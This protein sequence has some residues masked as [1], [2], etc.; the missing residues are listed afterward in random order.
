M[1]KALTQTKRRSRIEKNQLKQNIPYF[2]MM[3]PGI[4]LTF[5]F[6]YIPIF[7]IIIAF[8]KY[9]PS[10]GIWG[11]PWNGLK[12]FE[13]IFNSSDT[14]IVLRNTLLYNSVFIIG[15][16]VLNVAVALLLSSLR[17]KKLSKV[18]QTVVIMPHFLS[19]VIVA[20]IV[21]GFLN[22]E[23]GFI[24][25][26]ILEPLGLTPVNWYVDPK[27]W[28]VLL[29]VVNFWKTVGYGSVVYLAAIAGIDAELYE[30]A[31]M[32]GANRWKQIIHITLP[33]IKNVVIIML[34]MNVGKIF[35]SD[36]G[37]FYQVPMNSGALY[38]ATNVINVF[39]YNMLGQGGITGIGMSSAASFFQ[40]VVGFVLVL[41]T[42]SITKKID[43]EA[44]MF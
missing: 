28:P 31:E 33:S 19:M 8:K 14:P 23:T 5:I 21:Y 42:N 43:A 9:I 38:S 39:V 16:L 3:L 24:N 25:R 6:S 15:G 2:I 36:F 27:P 30:A 26:G 12:N 32:D 29:T 37:L 40:S 13:F 17:S 1:S 11:S 34:I 41:I 22:V 20:Y 4:I 44:A 10:L 18:C 7:G 35:N